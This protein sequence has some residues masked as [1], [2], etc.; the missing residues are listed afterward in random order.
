[1]T[2][3]HGHHAPLLPRA[4]FLRRLARNLLLGL[5][6]IAAS[7]LLGTAGYHGFAGLAWIDALLNASM[8]LTGMGPVDPLTTTGGK[9]FATFYSLFSGVAFLSIVGVM[10][11]PMVHR[12]LHRFHLDVEGA[13]DTPGAAKQPT[14]GAGR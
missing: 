4:V 13:Q 9:L 3:V 12:F 1:V 11:A 6:F 5:V 14:R 10:V 2:A 8:I 7:L